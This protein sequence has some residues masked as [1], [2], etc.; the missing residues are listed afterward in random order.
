MPARGDHDARRRDVSEAVWRVL[1]DRGFGGLTL[2]AVAA[3]MN[4]STGLLTHYFPSKKALI[5]YALDVADERTANRP[6]QTTPEPGLEGLRTAL[7]D[8]LPLT[9]EAAAMNRVWV[10]SWDGSLA[11]PELGAREKDRYEAWR[12]RLRP[13]VEAARNDGDLPPDTDIDEVTATVAAFTHGI[14]V[15]ALFDPDRFPP[16]R[17]TT[18]LN[19]LLH[20]LAALA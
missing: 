13:H 1:A 11:D 10:S 4:A 8:V 2:R 16:T 18:L 3:E 15:Q 17:Q 6:R 9:P 14:V 5:A 12:S 19:N 20:S 7:L